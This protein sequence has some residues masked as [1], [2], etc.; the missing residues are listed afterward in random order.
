MGKIKRII[1]SSDTKYMTVSAPNRKNALW[2]AKKQLLNN[3]I[4][5]GV[6]RVSKKSFP[7]KYGEYIYHVFYR[8]KKRAHRKKEGVNHD[9]KKK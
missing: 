8:K 3:E 4:I 5:L 1:F 6:H 9:T 2:Q 7:G